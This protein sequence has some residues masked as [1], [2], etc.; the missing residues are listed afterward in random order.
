[1][2]T[3]RKSRPAA[4]I[5]RTVVHRVSWSV[6]PAARG[7][8][9][10]LGSR[11]GDLRTDGRTFPS[12]SGRSVARDVIGN[13]GAR[14]TGGRD[15][16]WIEST[17]APCRRTLLRPVVVPTIGKQSRRPGLA[18]DSAGVPCPRV[19]PSRISHRAAPSFGGV[20][21]RRRCRSGLRPSQDRSA[22][23]VA[24]AMK[25]W[26]DQEPSRASIGESLDELPRPFELVPANSP[27]GRGLCFAEQWPHRPRRANVPGIET[28][29]LSI[30]RTVEKRGTQPRSPG[31]LA[32]KRAHAPW[33]RGNW[34]LRIKGDAPG[35][36][37][38]HSVFEI[39]PDS[40]ESNWDSRAPRPGRDCLSLRSASGLV[41]AGPQR[42]PWTR[43]SRSLVTPDNAEQ[44]HQRTKH[45][46]TIRTRTTDATDSSANQ[47]ERR[48]A[49]PAQTTGRPRVSHSI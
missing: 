12:R 31:N 40:V 2:D 45:P 19:H 24:V 36:A 34:P 9:L 38:G 47:F 33:S 7:D 42:H 3:A 25:P 41:G 6:M 27:R 18:S 39:F 8:S 30:S 29:P 26:R 22:H 28:R 13:P 37:L 49:G 43:R 20:N 23:G 32:V 10:N 4:H 11:G 1:M 15:I 21:R 5:T 35:A 44:P 16:S 48:D 14:L 17:L 46:R